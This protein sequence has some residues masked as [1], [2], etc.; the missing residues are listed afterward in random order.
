[1]E[2][3]NKESIDSNHKPP[4]VISFDKFNCEYYTPDNAMVKLLDIIPKEYVIWEPCAGEGHMVRFF[5]RHGYKVISTDIKYGQNFLN[6]KPDQPYD[7]IITN[8]PFNISNKVIQRCYS[9]KKP[10]MLLVP[11][12]ILQGNQRSILF[13]SYGISLF[14]LGERIDYIIP[15]HRNKNNKKSTSPFWSIWI[16]YKI[17]KIKT[18]SLNYLY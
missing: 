7:I 4:Y 13:Q 11:F 6:F 14:L 1:M 2:N 5:E 12:N 3:E 9:L 18:N 16:G 17:P 8:P 15:T 10:F